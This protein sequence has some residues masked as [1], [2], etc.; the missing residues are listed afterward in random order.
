MIQRP[1]HLRKPHSGKQARGLTNSRTESTGFF[2]TIVAL[3]SSILVVLAILQYHWSGQLSEAEYERMHSS[4][5]ASMNQFR[6]HFNNELQQPGMSLRPEI[7]ILIGGDWKKY[8]ADCTALLEMPD[9]RL[10]QKVYIWLGGTRQAPALLGLNRDKRIFES[11]SWPPGML[12]FREQYE[13]FFSNTRQPPPPMRPFTAITQDQG[14]FA[15]LPL[16]LP[17]RRFDPAAKD[18]FL[19]FV[20]IRLNR[21]MILNDVIPR[22]AQRYFGS[23]EGYI[24]H[25]AVVDRN[26]PESLLFRS[27]SRLTSDDFTE[28]DARVSLS[29]F[30]REPP[31]P[32]RGPGK[33]NPA[34]TGDF[35]PQ[36]IPDIRFEARLPL[37]PP[38]DMRREPSPEGPGREDLSWDLLAKHRAGSLEAAVTATRRRI[39]AISFG[40]L[41]LLAASVALILV[42]ARRAQ[43]LSQLQIDFVAGVSHEL[44]TPLAVICSAGDNLAEGVVTESGEAVRNYGNL[45]RGEGR[46][47]SAMVE[48][49][50]QF[51]GTGTGRRNYSLRPVR[52]NGIVAAALKQAQPMIADTGFSVETVLSADLPQAHTDPSAIS[53][54]LQNLIQN[55]IKYSGEKRLLCIRT[56]I[57]RIGPGTGIEL[58]VEDRGIGIDGKDLPHIFDAFYRGSAAI[59]RQIHGT[60][61]GLFFV[62]ETLASLGG[63]IRVESTPG[64]GS[65]FTIRLPAAPDP[66]GT[67]TGVN[68][69]AV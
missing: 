39:L 57:C 48:Q 28:P 61:L 45:I 64:F 4:L 3:L 25:V 15:I 60:G 50:M 14:A 9:Y 1:F 11:V 42:T 21:S 43:R 69:H 31:G 65:V 51:A 33:P 41:L 18:T 17:A 32:A 10:I 37:P 55:A 12:Q 46:K 54:I 40:S 63:D 26:A 67:F 59:A 44:R 13:R 34:D 53:Q 35:P 56:A 27:D 47:L 36:T 38:E 52:I 49:I 68:D 5:L 23:L 24:Y 62:Q 29:D 7:A 8:A 19:G 22:L 16:A 30:P 2:I 20:L 6:I 58:A 66:G